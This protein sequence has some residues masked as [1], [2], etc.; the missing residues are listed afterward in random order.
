MFLRQLLSLFLTVLFASVSF[1]IEKCVL[2]FNGIS[3]N[4]GLLKCENLNSS[5]TYIVTVSKGNYSKSFYAFHPRKFDYL[6]FAVP[7]YWSGNLTLSLYRDGL[8]LAEVPLKVHPLKGRISRIRLGV[9]GTKQENFEH[10]PKRILS[11]EEAYHLIRKV[12]K[13]FTPKRF[14][15]AKPTV[16]L[17]VYKRISSPFGGRRFINGRPAG[18]HKGVDFAAPKGTPVLATLSGKVVLAGYLPLTG[19]TVIIDHGW[20]LMSLYAHLSEIKVKYGQFVKQGQIIGKVGSTGR[21]TGPHLH[22]GIYLNDVAVD[23][24]EFLKLKLKPAEGGESINPPTSKR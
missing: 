23:P 21:S 24:L 16:P 2:T 19:N 10:H 4:L 7:Y 1:A 11:R 5:A 13:T 14:Y 12:L 9:R 8:K 17:R 20:G 15:E 6:L 18:V 3:G 22:F